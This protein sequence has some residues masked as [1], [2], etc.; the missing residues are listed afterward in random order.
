MVGT[1]ETEDAKIIQGS[2]SV[3]RENTPLF[4]GRKTEHFVYFSLGSSWK[5][6]VLISA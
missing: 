6:T 1:D 3:E 2:R 5:C 4:T